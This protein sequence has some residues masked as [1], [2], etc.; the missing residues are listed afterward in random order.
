M[1]YPIMNDP[2]PQRNQKIIHSG[3]AVTMYNLGNAYRRSGNQEMAIKNYEACKR[4]AD[5]LNI[6]SLVSKKLQSLV[7]FL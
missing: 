6:P 3:V 4:I 1:P 7:S 2:W 5:S